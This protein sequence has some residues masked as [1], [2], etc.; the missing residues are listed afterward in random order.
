MFEGFDTE[1][2]FSTKTTFQSIP[3]DHQPMIRF[4]MLLILGVTGAIPIFAVESLSLDGAVRR[5]LHAHPQLK[6][7]RSEIDI[8]RARLIEA[9]LLDN[10]EL[11]VVLHKSKGFA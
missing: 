6:A 3:P 1:L 9:G 10:P 5:A 7:A 11:Q 8:A 4:V 2:V